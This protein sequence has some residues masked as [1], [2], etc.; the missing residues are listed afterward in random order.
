[1]GTGD[2]IIKTDK[3]VPQLLH[4]MVLIVISSAIQHQAMRKKA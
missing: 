2:V 3:L 4:N 1:M